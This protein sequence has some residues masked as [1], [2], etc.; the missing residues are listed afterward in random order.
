MGFAIALAHA[1]DGFAV[2]A[3]RNFH[4][5]LDRIEVGNQRDG[6][7]II[8]A[9]AIIAGN[10]NTELTWIAAAKLDGGLRA[11]A[12]KIDCIVTGWIQGAEKAVGL[13][14]EQSRLSKDLR[15][16]ESKK[17]EGHESERL[18][19]VAAHGNRLSLP[20][21]K[22]WFSLCMPAFSEWA[23]HSKMRVESCWFVSR[24]SGGMK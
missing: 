15:A 18:S 5:A 9:D 10:H 19:A 13:F 24:D 22:I 23:A 16:A 20:G 14:H 21:K 17:C 8:W 12:R 3:L 6:D 4:R 11:D 2:H 7:P 1:H